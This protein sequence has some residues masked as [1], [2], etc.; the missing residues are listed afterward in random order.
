MHIHTVFLYSLHERNKNK[1][2]ENQGKRAAASNEPNE[3][4][5]TRNVCS[6]PDLKFFWSDK[7]EGRV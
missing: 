2:Y 7:E 6:W 3:Q 5:L 1:Y 4:D